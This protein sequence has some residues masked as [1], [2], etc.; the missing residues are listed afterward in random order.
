MPQRG[1]N[2]LSVE[3]CVARTNAKKTHTLIHTELFQ[4]FLCNYWYRMRFGERL[5][6]IEVIILGRVVR[7]GSLKGRD[8][9]YRA[10]Q[11]V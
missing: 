5:V 10:S 6:V 3:L 9:H 11:E 8:G 2:G 4:I 7:G 1:E